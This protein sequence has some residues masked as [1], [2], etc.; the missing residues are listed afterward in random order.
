MKGLLAE[1]SCFS[2]TSIKKQFLNFSMPLRRHSFL[3]CWPVWFCSA[4][5]FDHTALQY[6]R[7]V[8]RVIN[9]LSNSQEFSFPVYAVFLIF[10]FLALIYFSSLYTA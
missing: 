10:F 8:D 7:L 6:I 2:S 4:D 3:L 5:F 9:L 1:L